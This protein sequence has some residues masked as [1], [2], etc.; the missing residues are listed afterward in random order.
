M[1]EL[2]KGGANGKMIVGYTSMMAP[3]SD[4]ENGKVFKMLRLLSSDDQ[5]GD[6]HFFEKKGN[7][8]IL[9]PG[10]SFVN[11][12]GNQNL[13]E[14]YQSMPRSRNIDFYLFVELISKSLCL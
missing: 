12:N 11:L 4:R 14:L 5:E 2:V 7:A 1:R 13:I 9:V 10:C 8:W 6:I 3:T